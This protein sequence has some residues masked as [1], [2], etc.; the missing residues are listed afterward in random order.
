VE[1][2]HSHHARVYRLLGRQRLSTEAIVKGQ[3]YKYSKNARC[4]I[5]EIVGHLAFIR[6]YRG[7]KH[8]GFK[9][10]PIEELEERLKRYV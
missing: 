3:T 2:L 7:K 1:G 10:V 9:T 6:I 8:L 4:R 5:V